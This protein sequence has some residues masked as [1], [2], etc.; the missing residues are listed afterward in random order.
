MTSCLLPRV[1]RMFFAKRRHEDC[2][3]ELMP[4]RVAHVVLIGFKMTSLPHTVR[5]LAKKNQRVSSSVLLPLAAS[6]EKKWWW[7]SPITMGSER[8]H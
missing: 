7:W 1:G 8:L 4:P 6:F 5:N 2:A 3:G